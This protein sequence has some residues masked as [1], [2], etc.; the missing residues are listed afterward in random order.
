MHDCFLPLGRKAFRGRGFFGFDQSLD[1]RAETLLVELERLFT[2]AIEQEI[3][4]DL[5]GALE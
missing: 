1:F 2:V 5:H 4:A 3:W